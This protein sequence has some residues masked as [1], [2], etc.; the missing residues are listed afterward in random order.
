MAA[1]QSKMSSEEL[2]IPRPPHSV[3]I[4]KRDQILVDEASLESFPASDPPAWTPTHAGSPAPAPPRTETP[5]ELRS[6]LRADVARL[7]LTKGE[8][9][10]ELVTTAFLEAGRHVIRIPLAGPQGAENL[11]AVIRAPQDGEELVIGARL[12]NPTS[13]AVLLGLARVLEGRGFARTVR[14]VAFAND[15]VGSDSYAKRLREQAIVLRGMLSLDSVGFLADRQEAG[16]MLLA[17]RLVATKL[18]G[19][20]DGSVIGF[21]AD[22]GSRAL[23][24]ETKAAFAHASRLEA[25]T[26]VL[27]PIVPVLGSSDARAF[28]K[29][30]FPAAGVTDTGPIRNKH[31][32]GTKDAPA[33][34]NYDCMADLVFGLASVVAKLAGGEPKTTP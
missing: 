19:S 27:P 9:T 34:L 3:H 32:H 25:R 15:H 29:E 11:E 17:L 21:V 22:R 4:E 10:S 28:A 18:L 31:A 26:F 23:L 24:D 20:W 8:Q 30:G 16:S 2:P 33:V 14:L 1:P 12:S 6:K 13:V 7:T 5:R